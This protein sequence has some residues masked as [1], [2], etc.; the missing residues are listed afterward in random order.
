MGKRRNS[1]E[2]G[3]KALIPNWYNTG[4]QSP[5]IQRTKKKLEFWKEQWKEKLGFRKKSDKFGVLHTSI[6]RTQKSLRNLTGKVYLFIVYWLKKSGPIYRLYKRL[7][8]RYNRCGT[9]KKQ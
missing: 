9:K 4:S 7:V 2:I 6:S 5:S 1:K 3:T 8:P